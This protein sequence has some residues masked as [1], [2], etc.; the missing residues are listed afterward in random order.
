MVSI[1][2]VNW[3]TAGL[4]RSC[5][6]SIRQ[7]VKVPHEVIVVDNDS[8]DGSAAMVRE[9][10]PEVNLV[11]PGKNTGYAAGNNLA[12]AAAR[13]DLL[14]TLNPDTEFTDDSLDCCSERLASLEGYGA[15][16]VRQIGIKGETQSSVRG[17][18]TLSGILGDFT[19]IG[20]RRPGT[21]WDSYRLSGLDYEKEQ[22]VPQPMGTFILFK[23]DALAKIGDPKQPFDEGFPIFF[24]EVDLMLR[25]ANA[26]FKCR[27]F[28]DLSIL[29]HGGEST[30]QVKKS[31][32]WES[33]R[34]LVRFLLKHSRNGFA[35]L[36]VHLLTPIIYAAAWVRA[37][38]YHAGF[39]P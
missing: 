12:F 17:F 4:L 28:P 8:S 25:L 30:K 5:L 39:R 27:Y 21:K 22:D 36:G 1:L 6:A 7:W 11:C 33:H 38:G 19:G 32:I 24:N 10:F 9:E 14:L 20:R 35:R 18:P 13:G 31:M 2:I 34:S 15:A 37:R 29:H 16:C 3:N 26:G 23:R